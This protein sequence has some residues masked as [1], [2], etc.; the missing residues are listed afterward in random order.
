MR[1]VGVLHPPLEV[2]GQPR[3]GRL[4]GDNAHRLLEEKRTDLPFEGMALE[5]V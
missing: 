5:K 2:G 1:E 4:V 3:R